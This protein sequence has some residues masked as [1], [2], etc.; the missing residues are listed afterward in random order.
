MG[1]LFSFSRYRINLRACGGTGLFKFSWL[2]WARGG[3]GIRV[4]LRSVS[5]K[6]WEFESPRAHSVQDGV[7]LEGYFWCTVDSQYTPSHIAFL[8]LCYAMNPHQLERYSFLWS[9]VRLV[10]AAVALFIGGVPPLLL[11]F[12][13]ASLASVLVILK[14][15]WLISGAASIFL[16]Y[17]WYTE[18][19]RVFGGKDMYDTLA[20]FV[21]V[22]SGLN[23]GLTGLIGQNVGMTLAPSPLLF[24][25]AAL[26]YLAL[27]S[28][29]TIAGARRGRRSF[30]RNVG[31]FLVI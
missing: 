22:V 12:P 25:L 16:L 19:Q 31:T 24:S 23:L 30:T 3:T 15:A 21:C 13:A 6:G 7:R 14:L 10:I 4:R 28:I 11:L 2:E 27:L 29:S 18:G 17:R 8:F 26:V 20:F 1:S 9:E 5:R